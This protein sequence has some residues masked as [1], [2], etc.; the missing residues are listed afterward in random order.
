MFV[1]ATV[2][3]NEWWLVVGGWWLVWGSFKRLWELPISRLLVS[4]LKSKCSKARRQSSLQNG[5]QLTMGVCVCVLHKFK[6][7]IYHLRG[8]VDLFS[9]RDLQ[10]LQKLA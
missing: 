3:E 2:E 1:H 10:V 8:M 7:I 6:G 9:L 4:D 5:I